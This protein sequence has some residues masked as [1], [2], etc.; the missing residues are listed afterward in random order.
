MNCK[1]FIIALA[2][3][4]FLSCNSSSQ[5]STDKGAKDLFNG[6]NLDGWH[7][8]NGK[9][10]YTVENGEIVGTTVVNTPDR[11]RVE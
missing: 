7:Q 1:H 2:F 4:P 8:L 5:D 3:L 11:K 10:K 9:A 6:K